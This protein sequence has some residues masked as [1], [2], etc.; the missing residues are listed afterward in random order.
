MADPVSGTAIYLIPGQSVRLR[1]PVSN[2][3]DFG[4]FAA[5]EIPPGYFGDSSP[6]LGAMINGFVVEDERV[7]AIVE[8]TDEPGTVVIYTHKRIEE[9]AIWFFSTSGERGL[10]NVI[11]VP[12]HD[13]STIVHGGPAYGTYFDDDS[14]RIGEETV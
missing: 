1:C 5:Q 8:A 2:R 13:H 6:R 3:N 11:S 7:G 9:N 12:I 14:E 10:V 4:W